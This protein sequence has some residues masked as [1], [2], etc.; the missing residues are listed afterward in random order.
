MTDTRF[1]HLADLHLGKRLKEFSLIEDQR[2]VLQQAVDLIRNEHLNGVLIAGD[3]FDSSVPTADAT[4]LFD[5]F[6]TEIH[7][8]GVPLFLISGNHDSAEKLQFG[9]RIFSEN[10]LYFVTNL[11]Q[12]L[13]PISFQG[14]NVY[15]LPFSKPIDVNY[16][17]GTTCKTYTEALSEVVKR[18]MVDSTKTNLLLAHQ[19]VL[20]TSAPL[21]VGGSESSINIKDGVAVGDVTA[22]PAE[23]FS[24]FDYVALGHIHRPQMIAKN[25]RYSGS[26][27]KYHKDEASIEKMF[28][29]LNVSNKTIT[30]ETRPIRYRHNVVVLK[31]SLEEIINSTADKDAYVFATLSDKSTLDDPMERLRKNFPFAAAIEYENLSGGISSANHVDIEHKSK[32]ELFGEFFATQNG[33]PM[34]EAQADLMHSLL[35]KE[36]P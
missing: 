19:T 8:L 25:A 15:L 17:F 24:C 14:I 5:N 3:I 6:I 20:P 26:I 11:Q 36:N 32:K 23:L 4:T 29:I 10:S 2:F 18:M 34:N 7:R 9:G 35:G 16:A 21:L 28:I 33:R 30:I 27:L 31:G 13:T 12:A 22:V 1:L